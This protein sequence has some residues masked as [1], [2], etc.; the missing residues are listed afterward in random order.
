MSSE[1][2][3]AP[4]AATATLELTETNVVSEVQA[5]DVSATPV[6]T[7]VAETSESNE[8]DIVVAHMNPLPVSDQPLD[9]EAGLGTRNRAAFVTAAV[10]KKSPDTPLGVVIKE[11][12]N[13]TLEISSVKER[14]ILYNSPLRAGDKLLSVNGKT[15]DEMGKRAVLDFLRQVEG[16]LTLV[17]HNPG[18]EPTLVETM[19]EKPSVDAVVGIAMRWNERGSLEISKI[20]STGLFGHSLLVCRAK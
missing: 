6:V 2:A 9:I 16:V 20:S 15:C 14:G 1:D 4:V 13:G 12:S 11:D 7:A 19:I 3:A 17:A 8:G 10:V 5:V 18:G